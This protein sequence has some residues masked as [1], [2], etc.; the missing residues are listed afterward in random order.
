MTRLAVVSA[1]LR[2]PSS[3]RLLADRLRDA[4]S[5]R[6]PEPVEVTQIEVR[7]HMHAITDALLS[8]F[9]TG[10]LAEDLKAVSEADAIIVVTPTFQGSF[11][12]QF[13]SFIDLIEVGA[14]KHTP[15][16][17]AATG[18]S[19]RHSLVIEYALRP[20]F[21]YL[22]AATV[23]TGVYAATQDFGAEASAL[24]RRVERAAAELVALVGAS[25][26]S[27]K[28]TGEEPE[29]DLARAQGAMSQA[30]GRPVSDFGALLRAMGQD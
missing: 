4:A 23:P 19:E 13:K 29:D 18:G 17:L 22:G 8:G 30:A 6:L 12:G 5:A 24:E 2:A 7:D 20:V 25:T 10:K 1:G 21:A 14:L 26:P 11:A 15:V 3:T 28:P 27:N 16:L 9:P